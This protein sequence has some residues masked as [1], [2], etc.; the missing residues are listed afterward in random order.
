LIHCLAGAL[1]SYM[2]FVKDERAKVVAEN[3]GMPVTEVSKVIGTRWKELSAEAKAQYETL[4]KG[5]KERYVRCTCC[6][7]VA[8]SDPCIVRVMCAG[9]TV[10]WPSTRRPRRRRAATRT[11]PVTREATGSKRAVP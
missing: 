3:P 5:D 2:F 7:P 4:A 11:A 8:V 6:C 9:T 10:K 1:G